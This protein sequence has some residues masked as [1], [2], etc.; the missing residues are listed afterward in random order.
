MAM[1]VQAEKAN[2]EEIA[3]QDPFW[4]VLAFPWRKR[5]GWEP[6]EFYATGELEIAEVIE[7]CERLGRPARR[8]RALDFGCGLGRLTR[9]LSLRFDTALGVDISEN[10]ATRARML[11][12]DFDCE[13]YVNPWPDLRELED[14]SFDL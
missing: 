11:N 10:M 14:D 9:A 1:E 6:D 3:S 13:F 2:W 5:G 7:R 8:E 4:A 12:E